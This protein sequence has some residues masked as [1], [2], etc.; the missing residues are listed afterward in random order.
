MKE[1]P[2]SFASA[3]TTLILVRS[4]DSR[5]QPARGGGGAEGSREGNAGEGG[6]VPTTRVSVMPNY[7]SCLFVTLKFW[8]IFNSDD[9][10]KGLGW[11]GTDFAAA[12]NQPLI[13]FSSSW[14]FR[15]GPIRR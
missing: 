5:A 6:V 9:K 12:F 14:V 8:M 15:G 2:L 11:G 10:L 3:S 1:Q 13:T 4:S 7:C